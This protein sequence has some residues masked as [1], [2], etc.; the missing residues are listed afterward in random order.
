M[1]KDLIVPK[2]TVNSASFQCQEK[3]EMLRALDNSFVSTSVEN[4]KNWDAEELKL[5][6]EEGHK[7]FESRSTRDNLPNKRDLSAQT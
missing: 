1:W 2:E 6:I 7:K 4:D 3:I 5:T